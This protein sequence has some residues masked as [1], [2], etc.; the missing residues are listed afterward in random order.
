MQ[1]ILLTF[2]F[3]IYISDYF[4]HPLMFKD[5]TDNFNEMISLLVK[6]NEG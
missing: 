5:P 2:L 6:L 1:A 4:S 3:P